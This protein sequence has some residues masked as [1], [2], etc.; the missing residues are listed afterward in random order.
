MTIDWKPWDKAMLKA[1]LAQQAT[2]EA[3]VEALPDQFDHAYLLAR[4][5][6]QP[7]E[8]VDWLAEQGIYRARVAH[9]NRSGYDYISEP[10][11]GIAVPRLQHGYG[12]HPRA[13]VRV[14]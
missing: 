3:I 14:I 5:A 1:K 2:V 6:A 9:W 8:L 7:N 12:G 13:W 11:D 4:Y 10:M